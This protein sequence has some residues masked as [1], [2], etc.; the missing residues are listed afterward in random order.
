M[1]KQLR[2]VSRAGK[3]RLV[4]CMEDEEGWVQRVTLDAPE[5]RWK[6]VADVRAFVEE[7]VAASKK[8]IVVINA[9]NRDML[10]SGVLDGEG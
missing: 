6:T 3:I 10:L 8:G 9:A 4:Y 5:D 7:V 1:E 2:M